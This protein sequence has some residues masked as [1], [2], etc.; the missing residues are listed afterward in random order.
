M[1]TISKLAKVI[2]LTLIGLGISKSAQSA[3]NLDYGIRYTCTHEQT[4]NFSNDHLSGTF[5]GILRA[6]STTSVAQTLSV[7]LDTQSL[8]LLSLDHNPNEKYFRYD[9]NDIKHR[10]QSYSLRLARLDCSDTYSSMRGILRSNNFKFETPL[11]QEINIKIADDGKT[12]YSYMNPDGNYVYDK[13]EIL[14]QIEIRY[15]WKRSRFTSE[16]YSFRYTCN[17]EAL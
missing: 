12:T 15:S 16:K 5:Q 17:F 9:N 7:G 11:H 10:I 3:N 6:G 4:T 1:K 2:R 13:E 14:D 8:F